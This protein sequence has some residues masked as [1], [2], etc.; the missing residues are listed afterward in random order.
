MDTLWAWDGRHMDTMSS[1]DTIEVLQQI[2]E[3]HKPK[4]IMM[5]EDVVDVYT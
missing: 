2:I 1:K 5:I 4:N 3:P